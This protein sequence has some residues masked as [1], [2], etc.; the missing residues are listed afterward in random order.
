MLTRAVTDFRTIIE[1]KSRIPQIPKIEEVDIEFSNNQITIKF[2]GILKFNFYQNDQIK[3]WCYGEVIW[4][5]EFSR[6]F[7]DLQDLR[8]FLK[9]SIFF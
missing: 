6:L 9:I 8:I 7:D 5:F 2:N 4:N 3:I 1:T